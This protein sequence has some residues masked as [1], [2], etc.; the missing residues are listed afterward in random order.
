MKNGVYKLKERIEN[1]CPSGDGESWTNSAHI[2]PGDEDDYFCA[3]DEFFL[4]VQ[5][6]PIMGRAYQEI[7][8]GNGGWRSG[9]FIGEVPK[10]EH[11]PDLSKR[12]I[13]DEVMGW[14]QFMSHEP[15][16]KELLE[17][18]VP[19]KG[20]SLEE[21]LLLWGQYPDLTPNLHLL[22]KH[23]WESTVFRVMSKLCRRD[24]DVLSKF[25]TGLRRLL[26]EEAHRKNDFTFP[27][28]QQTKDFQQRETKRIAEQVAKQDR[29]FD[30]LHRREREQ[31]EK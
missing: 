3:V 22:D 1:P 23:H 10:A 19:I 20:Q 29:A 8:L 15:A 14:F 5:D 25:A 7:V 31:Q 21:V 9:F 6:R 27:D 26:I 16:P 4:V 11:F 2:P 30:K 17:S 13:D 24:P 18:L 12:V 28:P